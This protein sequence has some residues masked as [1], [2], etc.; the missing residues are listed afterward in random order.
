MQQVRSAEIEISTR[1][2]VG[3][4]L[5]RSVMRNG[6]KEAL[7]FAD[8]SWTYYQLDAAVNR[9]ANR[10]LEA[11]LQPGDRV[12]A[13][14]KNS[15][16]YLLLWLACARSGLIHVPVNFALVQDELSYIFNQSGARAIFADAA[17]AA[18]VDSLKEQIPATIFGS[19]HSPQAADQGLD[20]L[21][22][23]QSDGSTQAPAVS[24][25]P[26]VPG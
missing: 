11:G 1:N 25:T 23:A 14:G 17:L 26:P 18:N 5:A 20:I 8:R 15:D 2:T 21:A 3:D 7:V 13:Y 16:A 4:A 24:L 12:A 9:V 10:L 19:L 6:N 22:I